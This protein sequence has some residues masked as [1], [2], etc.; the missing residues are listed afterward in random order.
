MDGYQSSVVDG[1]DVDVDELDAERE[2]LAD[3]DPVH[4]RI[5]FQ[6]FSERRESFERKKLFGL[7]EKPEQQR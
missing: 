2:A 3:G 4:L 6:Q 1:V 7:K 5:L